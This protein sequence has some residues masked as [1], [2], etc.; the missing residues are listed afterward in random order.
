[1][2]PSISFKTTR[3]VSALIVLACAAMLV[4]PLALPS[5]LDVDRPAI[6]ALVFY[7]VTAGAYGALPFVRRGDI[8]MVAMWLMLAVGIAP[9][10]DGR[11][12]SA[13]HMFAD[14]LGVLMAV[15][16]IYL[17]RYRQVAQGDMR[18]E[19]R[20]A[21]KRAAKAAGSGAAISGPAAS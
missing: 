21:A 10:V 4:A 9:C 17:A 2:F 16:P 7:L 11:E 8:A 15:A 6:G 19:D 18:R 1:M 5:T 3:L 20:R 14:M 13:P 12:I